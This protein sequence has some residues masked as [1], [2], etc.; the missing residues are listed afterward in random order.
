ME[1]YLELVANSGQVNTPPGSY[2]TVKEWIHQSFIGHDAQVLEV[3]CSTGFTTIEMARYAGA[4]CVGLDVHS[5]SLATAKENTDPYVRD[6]VK[7]VE[8]DAGRI[9]FEDHAFSHTIVGGHLPFVTAE[10]RRSHIAEAVR[11]TRPWGYLLTALYFYKE[12]PPEL[13]IA[14]FNREVGTKLE[15]GGDLVYWSSLFEGQ[16]LQLEYESVHEVIPPDDQRK[17]EYLA[18]LHPESRQKWETRV[19]L[20]AENGCYL[21]YFVRVYRR[22]PEEGG[23]MIQVPRGGIYRT[24]RL[25]ERS[26]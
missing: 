17:R 15:V 5:G 12:P 19:A 8:G 14:R 26:Y 9:P 16:P 25:S 2:E 7:F 24:Q 3:G 22:M 10:L 11:V 21:R 18:R 23:L 1:H 4:S 13:L 6:R 20:F